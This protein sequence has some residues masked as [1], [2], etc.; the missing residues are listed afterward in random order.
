MPRIDPFRQ[1]KVT[2][3]DGQVMASCSYCAVFLTEFMMD[4]PGN[5]DYVVDQASKH[6]ERFHTIGDKEED[7]VP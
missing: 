4:K 5:R 7:C 2:R 3:R 6:N 1:A